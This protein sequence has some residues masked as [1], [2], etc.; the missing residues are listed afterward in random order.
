MKI[1][2]LSLLCLPVL[3]GPA[4]TY[5]LTIQF[6]DIRYHEGTLLLGFYE[7][8]ASWKRR[9][10]AFEKIISKSGLQ[11][12]HLTIY[13]DQLYAKRYGIAV[14]DDAN[15]NNKVD[16]GLIFPEEGFGFSNYYHSTFLP[17]QYKDFEFPFPQTSLVKVKMR[18][19]D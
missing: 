8:E 17:P 10:P 6:E 4:E 3:A 16:F 1:F 7:D 13:V 18:Y 11:N 5:R 12:G 9:E 15:N 14:L 2:L 19:L